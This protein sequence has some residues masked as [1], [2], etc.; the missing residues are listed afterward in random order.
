MRGATML[1]LS[2]LGQSQIVVDYILLR[3]PAPRAVVLV[4]GRSTCATAGQGRRASAAHRALRALAR[5]YNQ[6]LR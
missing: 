4:T 5:W 2:A 6:R 3:E 1:G